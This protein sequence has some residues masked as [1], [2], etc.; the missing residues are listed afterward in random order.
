MIEIIRYTDVPEVWDEYVQRKES[1]TIY[2]QAG[3]KRVIEKSFG[4][5]PYYLVAREEEKIKGIL[6]LFLLKSRLFGRFLVSLPFLNYGGICA[7]DEETISLLFEKAVEV[8]KAEGAEYIE[9]R[10]LGDSK[11][12]DLPTKTNKVT[13]LLR[14]TEDLDLFW[15]N[16]EKRVR[17]RIRK[18]TKEGLVIKKGHNHLDDFYGAF[19]VGMKEH[20][21]PVYHKSFFKNVIE[22]FNGNSEIFVAYKAG[23]VIGAKLTMRFKDTLYLIWGSYPRKY[24]QYAPNYLLTWEAIKYSIDNGLTF[25]DFGRCTNGLGTY[26]FKVNWGAQPKQLYWQYWLNGT[27]K[28]P[29]LNPNNPKYNMAI[30]TWRKLPLFVTRML[31]PG[32]AKNIP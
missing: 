28:I 7:D 18:A 2:H 15:K 16:L 32:I 19:A 10:Y 8:A 9:L 22:I 31:G 5:R 23:K 27:S 29:E 11:Q 24:R 4:H 14:I 6:P 17:N 1:A 26:D 21:I 13:L 3:W 30:K 25:V 20:G 12:N